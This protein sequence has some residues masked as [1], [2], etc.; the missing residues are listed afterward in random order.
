M[1]HATYLN[2]VSFSKRCWSDRFLRTYMLIAQ[3][4]HISENKFPS[5]LDCFCKK[6]SDN[7]FSS[8]YS[9]SA[10]SFSLLKK[11]DLVVQSRIKR[12][13]KNVRERLLLFLWL[14]ERMRQKW[15]RY[16]LE[17]LACWVQRVYLEL[18]LTWTVVFSV[19]LLYWWIQSLWCMDKVV[20]SAPH[21]LLL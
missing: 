21:G 15:L 16:V 13:L 7:S 14:F 12:S 18:L 6:N 2:L 20:Y 17:F 11:G 10:S 8:F 4:I 9:F 1:L 5:I 19:V 3:A